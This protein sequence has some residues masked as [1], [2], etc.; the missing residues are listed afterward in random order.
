MAT[1]EITAPDGAR[2]QVEGE[3]QEGALAALQQ[4]LGGALRQPRPGSRACSRISTRPSRRSSPAA[5]PH[6]SAGRL[7]WRTLVG[8]PLRHGQ[9]AVTGR[10]Y[11]EVKAE[12]DA[13]AVLPS[14]TLDKLGSGAVKRAIVENITGGKP[15]YEPQTQPGKFVGT[16]LEMAPSMIGAGGFRSGAEMLG[17]L[18]A[19][20]VI[21][22][23]ARQVAHNVAPG[24]ETP[25]A[26]LG[27]VVGGGGAALATRTGVAEGAIARGVRGAD[28][29]VMDR[30]ADLMRSAQEQGVNL[31]WTQAIQQASNG[32]TRLDTLER[33][34]GG[35]AAGQEVLRPFYAEQPAQAGAA[36][37]RTLDTVTPTPLP[38]ARAGLEVQGAAEGA[39]GDVQRRINAAETPYYDRANMRRSRPAISSSS[40]R[41]RLS[42]A[43]FRTC[44]ATPSA[45]RM[46][47]ASRPMMSRR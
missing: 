21:S 20:P 15:L 35:T 39:V 22:E 23:G 37:N 38:P 11:D 10:P 34:V 41:I 13:R 28:D 12:A 4:H 7:M 3:T 16:A 27:A 42:S 29:A 14:T 6:G 17:Q 43:R 9:G 1:F 31:S 8:W 46:W 26:V 18:V 47:R 19:P 2:Y 40:P 24:Y 44:A 32:A 25:A 30:A 33:Q 5:L 36:V 45:T